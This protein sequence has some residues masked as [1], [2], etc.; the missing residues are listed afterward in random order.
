MLLLDEPFGALDAFTREELWCTLR[1]LQAAQKFNVILVTHDLR[2]SVFLADTVYVMSKSPGRFVVSARSTCRARATWRSPTRRSSP[3]SCTSCAATSARCASRPATPS[4]H[5][6]RARRMNKSSCERWAPLILLVAM[7]ALWQLICSAFDVSEFIFPSP[8]R[9]VEQAWRA[10]LD[11]PRP[12]LAHLLGH[13]GRLRHRHRG[14]RAAGLPDRQLAPGLRRDVPADDGL[15]RAAQGGLRADP[16]RVVRHRRRAG[17]PDRVP[18]LASSRSW[19]TSPPAWPR[20][21][22]SWKTCCAC[23]ARKRWDVLVK[24]GLPRSMPYFYGSLKVAITLAFVGTTVSRDDRR[25]RGH[26]LPAASRPA[27]RCRWAWPSPAWWWSARWRWRMYELFSV[28]EKRTTG[29]A[30]R[31]SRQSMQTG[32]LPTP[33]APG[34]RRPSRCCATCAAPTRWRER[35]MDARPPPLRRAARRARPRDRA[36]RTG[37]RRQREPRRSGARARRSAPTSRPSAVGLHA[38]HH[39]RA[40]RDVRRHA[41]LGA[42]RPAGLRHEREPAACASP[43]TTPRTRR[44]TCPAARCSRAGRRRS[45][46]WGPVPEVEEEIAALHRRLLAQRAELRGFGTGGLQS[47]HDA[48]QRQRRC[49]GKPSST[50]TT[51]ATVMRTVRARPPRRAAARAAEPLPGGRPASATTCWCIRRA[52]SSAATCWTSMP[53]LERGATR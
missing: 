41:V 32:A 43:A 20:W 22:P 31:G 50:C 53:R 34:P 36:A 28:V 5:P 38:R 11:D 21:S 51:P 15:Q 7:L 25:Q 10:P 19:S 30:H 39:R 4:G 26:R 16:G 1:D 9:I 35:A 23:S 13:D 27:R 37:Q 45:R 46:V 48:A 47:G 49:P 17:D 6:T 24:V 8:W 2:E 14:R 3:T 33:T 44:S 29:W 40:L 18:D 42:H 52:A 12:R